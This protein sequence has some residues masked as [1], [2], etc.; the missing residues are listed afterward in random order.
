M[1][2]SRTVEVLRGRL[3]AI[4]VLGLGFIVACVSPSTPVA[5]ATA[6]GQAGA[7][8]YDGFGL[9]F[10]A[11]PAGNQ[12]YRYMARGVGYNVYLTPRGAVFTLFRPAKTPNPPCASPVRS[13]QSEANSECERAKPD[14]S[15]VGRATT[16]TAGSREVVAMRLD[17]IGANPHAT[18]EGDRTRAT[19]T[20]YYQA[21]QPLRQITTYSRVRY[22]QVY[23]G[24]DMIYYTGADGQLEYDFELAA[25]ADPGVIRL[26]LEGADRL[27]LD[28]AGD[29]IVGLEG[30]TLHQ[31]APHL[32]QPSQKPGGAVTPV[33]G[34]YVLRGRQLSFA[35]GQYDHKRPLVIDPSV[36]FTRFVGGKNY[37][38]SFRTSVISAGGKIYLSGVTYSNAGPDGFPTGGTTTGTYTAKADVFLA[39]LSGDGTTLEWIT[40]WGSTNDD[41]P[42]GMAL[43][44]DRLFVNGASSSAT[45]PGA[46]NTNSGSYDGFVASFK[47]SDGT[48][49]GARFIGGSSYDGAYNIAANPSNNTVYLAGYAAG[50]GFPVTTGGGNSGGYDAFVM[51]LDG[52]VNTPNPVY[53]RLLG[54]VGSDFATAIG[55]DSTGLIY[56]AG[57]TNSTS[58]QGLAPAGGYD[59]FVTSLDPTKAAPSDVLSTRLL[60][61]SGT[62]YAFALTI[63]NGLIYVAGSTASGGLATSGS[64]QTALSGGSDAYVAR[65]SVSSGNLSLDR[66]TYLGGN[67]GTTNIESIESL[68]LD[69]AGTTLYLSMNTDSSGGLAVTDGSSFHPSLFDVYVAT[70]DSALTS[71]SYG[72]YLGGNGADKSSSI[73]LDGS[74][75]YVGGFTCSGLS[76]FAGTGFGTSGRD[77][78][79]GGNGRLTPAGGI[80]DCDAFVTKMSF[81][82]PG[83][84]NLVN[85]VADSSGTTLCSL[86]DAITAVQT[87]ANTGGC[88]A[89]M[90]SGVIGFDPAVFGSAQTITLS[91]ALP[92]IT[93]LLTITGPANRVT[94]NGN[95]VVS[96]VFAVSGTSANL[97]LSN[98]VITG[99]NAT[100]GNYPV[101]AGGGLSNLSGTVTV[102]NST[103]TG[104]NAFYA[105]GLFNQNGTM[106][107]NSSTISNN[108]ASSADGAVGGGLFNNQGTLAVNNS[109][110]NGNTAN[111]GG[112]I[113]SNTNNG[114]SAELDITTSTISGN[115]SANEGGGV[116]NAGGKTFVSNSTISGNTAVTPDKGNG[117]YA[118]NSSA[119]VYLK[120]SLVAANASVGDVDLAVGNLAQFQSQGYNLVGNRGSV[121]YTT[122]SGDQIGTTT[123]PIDP[124]LGPLASNGGPTQTQALL[125]GSPALDAGDPS[126]TSGND[127]RG[128]GYSRVKGGRMDIGA[129]E[130]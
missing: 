79:T 38:G 56:L 16:Q 29:L 18:I 23:P 112:G 52:S 73:S 101:N 44:S 8:T 61:G 110:I 88:L 58:F 115:R 75:L 51:K 65:Y 121:T 22:K 47:L 106:T 63:G 69:T 126:V 82:P 1:R 13:S 67:G 46:V 11:A 76:S 87:N 53:S 96:H 66:L 43:G 64:L 104:N 108:T 40:Y 70:L 7:T 30:Q 27:E 45:L 105:A 117:I 59:T 20:N 14:T 39:R 31:L 33:S 74:N 94:I 34:R 128:V 48:E 83:P 114:G 17:L 99:G 21:D 118:F 98:L 60:G 15:R 107:V 119:I 120:N 5:S 102:S 6:T 57:Y 49:L 103:I 10:E 80:T 24:I 35:V 72:G 130:A 125:A 116:F 62:D 123:V 9:G 89:G 55:Y 12:N 50:T 54:G 2:S 90:Q 124:K 86:R 3:L 32:Y 93:S 26:S 36:V 37:D 4:V 91:S 122:N 81:A 129:Y 42:Y 85:T 78:N 127:Q 97:T 92:T 111:E 109:T 77:P 71:Q 41:I 113:Y 28:A 95:N 100:S 25:G 19:R 84:T 68:A